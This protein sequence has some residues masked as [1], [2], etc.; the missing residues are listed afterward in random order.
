MFLSVLSLK[1]SDSKLQQAM[2]V[3]KFL[4]LIEPTA[5]LRAVMSAKETRSG[6]WFGGLNPLQKV[7]INGCDH[8]QIWHMVDQITQMV[9]NQHQN[10]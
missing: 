4:E 10:S 5:E 6:Y 1:H 3:A 9:G 7:S 8:F 2:L